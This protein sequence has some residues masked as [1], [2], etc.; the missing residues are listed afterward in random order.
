VHN[1]ADGAVEAVFEGPRDAVDSLVAWCRRGPAG[2]D[3]ASAEVEWEPPRG[4]HG[5]AIR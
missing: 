2:A 4:E 1:R 5:F 3:V